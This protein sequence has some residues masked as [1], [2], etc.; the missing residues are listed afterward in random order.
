MGNS[1]SGLIGVAIKRADLK[2]RPHDLRASL[3]TEMHDPGVS[4]FI[5][6]RSM[7][8]TN[9][10]TTTLYLQLRPEGIRH[11]FDSLPEITIPKC[12]GRRRNQP[13]LA[14]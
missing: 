11:G 7:R 8:H 6:Q 5:V 9:M 14:A 3:A 1:V 13:P 4:D 12:S 10:D 2:H